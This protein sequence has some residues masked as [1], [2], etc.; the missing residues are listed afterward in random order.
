MAA[1]PTTS[2]LKPMPTSA[3]VVDERHVDAEEAEDES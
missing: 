2:R 3:V 1:T